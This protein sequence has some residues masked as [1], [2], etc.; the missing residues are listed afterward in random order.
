MFTVTNSREAF[1]NLDESNV[2]SQAE[3]GRQEEL[4]S[5][6]QTV[7][8]DQ[9]CCTVRYSAFIHWR[10]ASRRKL[11]HRRIYQRL[12]LMTTLETPIKWLSDGRNE[13]QQV[14]RETE[15]SINPSVRTELNHLLILLI[16]NLINFIDFCYSS[17]VLH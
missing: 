10:S 3:M 8:D 1:G 16:I 17:E 4:Q 6:L 14:R 2:Q 15:S 9:P 13:L 7:R 12:I 11:C 5:E